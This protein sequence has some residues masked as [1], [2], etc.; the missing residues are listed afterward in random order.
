VQ[1]LRCVSEGAAL[2]CF[3]ALG[4]HQFL[5]PH[6][7]VDGRILAPKIGLYR[8]PNFMANP[9]FASTTVKAFHEGADH[10]AVEAW[11]L[12][13]EGPDA[14]VRQIGLAKRGLAVNL[15]DFACASMLSVQRPKLHEN[16]PRG[17]HVGAA[18]FDIITRDLAFVIGFALRFISDFQ[19]LQHRFD[20]GIS[21]SK[22]RAA[23][24]LG[25]YKSKIPTLIPI[26]VHAEQMLA[27]AQ[28]LDDD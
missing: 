13:Q 1:E 19:F 8:F 9:N 15:I 4:D 17:A 5:Q 21:G 12:L 6:E 16:S 28:F 7:R 20:A 25:I 24:L 26:L 18:I 22:E 27:E 11:I 2:D 14:E 10:P 3:D 23:Q